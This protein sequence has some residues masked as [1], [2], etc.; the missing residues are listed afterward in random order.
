[1][2]IPAPIK[3]HPYIVMGVVALVALYFLWPSSSAAPSSSG[4]GTTAAEIAA[5]AQIQSAQ[6]ASQG[7]IAQTESNNSAAVQQASIASQT[8]IA[9]INAQTAQTQA[10]ASAASYTAYANAIGATNVANASAAAAETTANAQASS[11]I[12]SSIMG[13]LS[14]LGGSLGAFGMAEGGV[15]GSNINTAIGS[16]NQQMLGAV[17][18]ATNI[19]TF[20]NN[21]AWNS[22]N[23]ASNYNNTSSGW[24]SGGGFGA[25][26][27]GGGGGMS[28][29]Q[30]GSTGSGSSQS[31][32]SGQS[33]GS[34]QAGLGMTGQN[35]VVYNPNT[36]T[37]AFSQLANIVAAYKP[38]NLSSVAP[39][40][41]T[42]S[43]PGGGPTIGMTR[44][45]NSS[46]AGL[47]MGAG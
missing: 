33:S 18:G 19:Q 1:M 17:L 14:K 12:T 10:A 16:G 26:W 40:I 29:G 11:G 4:S 2:D 20:S 41:T 47:P 45:V 39:A 30:G 3:E 42:P 23:A 13:A 46:G 15:Q 31:W 43:S 25:G 37:S 38:P 9:G 28:Y 22:S 6:I 32:S 5:G 27:N 36:V 35:A 21:G 24:H 7:A 8:S 44:T 34:S